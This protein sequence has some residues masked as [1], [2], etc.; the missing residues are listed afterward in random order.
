VKAK[1][2]L[3]DIGTLERIEIV[4]DLRLELLLCDWV[5]LLRVALTSGISLVAIW[6]LIK[7]GPAVGSA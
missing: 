4:R 2:L 7:K 1:Y 3:S 5:N 6:M